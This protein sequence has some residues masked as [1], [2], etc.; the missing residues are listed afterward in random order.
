MFLHHASDTWTTGLTKHPLDEKYLQAGDGHDGGTFQE[1]P[2]LHATIRRGHGY[3]WWAGQTQ[4]KNEKRQRERDQVVD[5][6]HLGKEKK[7]KFAC[8]LFR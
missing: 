6:E 8:V 7:R 2:P 5:A 4:S 1:R 3:Q